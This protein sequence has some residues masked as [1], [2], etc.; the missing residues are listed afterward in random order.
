MWL[1]VETQLKI[2]TQN[3]QYSTQ[4]VKQD[5]EEAREADP[6]ARRSRFAKSPRLRKLGCLSSVQ[7]A[8]KPRI[9]LS[10]KIKGNT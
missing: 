9:T 7:H 8:D 5:E 10:N 2:T 4:L 6:F 1:Q 3:N